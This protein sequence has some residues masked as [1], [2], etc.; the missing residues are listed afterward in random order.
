M[1]AAPASIPIQPVMYEKAKHFTL[2]R[3]RLK[4]VVGWSFLVLGFIALVTP[5]TP[6]AALLLAAGCE[7]V[8]LRLV[9]LERFRKSEESSVAAVDAPLTTATTPVLEG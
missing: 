1:Q 7:L 6:G 4:K 9:V 5:L 2:T 8:G 3:P